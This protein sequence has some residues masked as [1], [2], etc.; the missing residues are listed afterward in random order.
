MQHEFT[1]LKRE[2]KYSQKY[3][4]LLRFLVLKSK[5]TIRGNLFNLRDSK[6]FLTELYYVYLNLDTCELGNIL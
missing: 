6:F 1:R 3:D 5:R 2:V 4:Y